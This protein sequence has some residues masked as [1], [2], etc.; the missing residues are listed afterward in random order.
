MIYSEK[1]QLGIYHMCFTVPGSHNDCF[2]SSPDD[3]GTYLDF[4]KEYP[5]LQ[6]DLLYSNI[7]G[8][9]CRIDTDTQRYIIFSKQCGTK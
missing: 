1:T 5:Y 8:E 4:E 2:V 7:G 3:V 9:T 6:A